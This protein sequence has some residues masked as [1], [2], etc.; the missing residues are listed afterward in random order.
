MARS[1]INEFIIRIPTVQDGKMS[2]QLDG[3]KYFISSIRDKFRTELAAADWLVSD[4]AL[5]SGNQQGVGFLLVHLSSGTPTGP[6]WFLFTGNLAGTTGPGNSWSREAGAQLQDPDIWD[7]FHNMETIANEWNT[8]FGIHFAPRGGLDLDAALGYGYDMGFDTP[9]S[10]EYSGGDYSSPGSSPFSALDSFLPN[11]AP[12]RFSSKGTLFYHYADSTNPRI[13]SFLI[14]D[15]EPYVAVMQTSDRCG[16][17]EQISISGNIVDAFEPATSDTWINEAFNVALG[18]NSSGEVNR[19]FVYGFY[20]NYGS[21]GDHAN[22]SLK[23]M[24][25]HSYNSTPNSDQEIPWNS[26]MIYDSNEA[27]RG[28]IKPQVLREQGSPEFFDRCLYSKGT[29]VYPFAKISANY[30]IGWVDNEPPPFSVIDHTKHR[31]F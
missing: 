8:P 22:F 28:F 30:A 26:V 3:G 24:D 16:Y 2:P 10:G 18:F 19:D 25:V 12:T 20:N 23:R 15:A 17:L 1:Y 9:A 21:L 27:P 13:F 4:I 5:W 14:D 11:Q 29:F 6:A 7:H 31:G